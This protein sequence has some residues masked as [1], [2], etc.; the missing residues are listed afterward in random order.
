MRAPLRTSGEL[1]TACDGLP[2]PLGFVPTMGALHDGHLE[3]VRTARRRCA[4]VVASVFVNPTQF[5]PREVPGEYPRD[6]RRDLELMEAEGV[7]AVFV[8]SVSDVYP[9]GFCTSIHVDGPL[10]ACFEGASRPGHFDGVVTVVVKLLNMVRPDALF[11]GEKDA[12]QLAVIRRALR[13]LDMAVEV[14]AVPTVRE[15]DGLALSSRNRRLSA[16]ERSAAPRLHTALRAG[17]QLAAACSGPA[18]GGDVVAAVRSGLHSSPGDTHFVVDY[19]AVVDP[20]TFQ[21][22]ERADRDAL[23]IAAARL[24]GVRLIDNIRISGRSAA[25]EGGGSDDA[26]RGG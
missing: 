2:R 11:L 24:G 5:G 21:S 14:A 23:I 6:E 4:A 12:Q 7:A 22:L 8:P 16:I 20:D 26:S 9:H 17:R 10:T 13:D 19:V 18:S 15:P 25:V 1:R 3:L